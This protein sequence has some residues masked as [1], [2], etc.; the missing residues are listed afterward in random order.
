MSVPRPGRDDGME[1]LQDTYPGAGTFRFGDG[2]DLCARLNALVRAGTKTATCGAAAEFDAEP[3]AMP[4]VGRCDIATEWDGTPALVIRT[5][6]VQRVSFAAVTEEMALAEGADGLEGWRTEHRAFFER[7]GGFDPEMELIFEH[8]E[9][10]E[11]LGD[12]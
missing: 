4:V 5:T 7:N 11:D 6:R 1:D 3:E 9:L 10:V 12:R 2:P 8:F